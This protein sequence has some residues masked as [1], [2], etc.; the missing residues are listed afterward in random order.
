MST[1]SFNN[2]KVYNFEG[3]IRGMR[4]PMNSWKLS[5]SGID[6]EYGLD[7]FTD[8]HIGPKDLKLAKSLIKAGTEH[9]KFLRQ[10]FVC[11]DI[12]A[13]RYW[14]QEFDTY[15]VG[16]T[17]NSCS[18]MHKLQSIPFSAEM[19]AID[20]ENLEN[21]DMN[22]WV[23]TIAY[24]NHLREKYN[25]TKDMNTFRLLKQAL[26]ESFKQLRTITFNYENMLTFERQ[27]GKHRLKEWNEDFI[28]FVYSLPYAEEFI[29][30]TK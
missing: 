8:F 24:L 1:L 6:E 19:F 28:G 21:E 11:V 14:W 18:T 9:R 2:I 5:D 25:R 15:K 27:R 7:S 26:P 23:N 22:F 12:T 30:A 4:N 13:P 3:A 10:I 20:S 17:A 29:K 16:T